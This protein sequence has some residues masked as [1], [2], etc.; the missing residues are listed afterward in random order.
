MKY[1]KSRIQRRSFI[2]TAGTIASG[3]ALAP[4]TIL[5]G[6]NK[7]PGHNYHQL[8]RTTMDTLIKYG[9]DHYGAEN[10]PMFA[11]ILDQ[12]TLECPKQPPMFPSV[13]VRVD[14][15]RMTRRA[16][17]S[18]N[19][20]YDQY[21]FRTMNEMTKATGDPKYRNAVLDA[22]RFN[23]NHAVDNRGFPALGGHISWNLYTE[24]PND[25]DGDYHEL[26][27]WPMEW[28]LWWA[29]DPEKTRAYVDKIWEC[30]VIDKT[31]GETNRHSDK[32]HGWSFS[33]CDGTLMSAWAYAALQT[34]EQKYRDW[35]QKVLNYHWQRHNP[36]TGLMIGSG[37]QR[38]Q[39]IK[40]YDTIG[41]TTTVMPFA[42]N[43]LKIGK[44]LG[45]TEMVARG[46]TILDGYAKYGFD[47]DKK[48]F[49]S[50]LTLD[51]ESIRPSALRN[52]VD[53]KG[54]PEGYL[55]TWLPDAGWHEMPLF[56]AQLYVWAAENV[57]RNAYLP[58][59]K[60]FGAILSRA[61]NERYAGFKDW[62]AYSEAVKPFD[63]ELY[64]NEYGINHFKHV[65]KGDVDKEL[66]ENYR[67]GG[68]AYQAPFGLFADHY[69]RM[70]QFCNAM[71]KVTKEQS[72][73]KLAYEVADEAVAYLWRDKLFVGHPDKTTYE[74]SDQVGILLN[75]LMQL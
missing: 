75:A 59:A 12:N 25:Q 46:R 31:T 70:I 14:A 58:T 44:Q 41:F 18:A 64:K 43:L 35:I 65:P 38:G 1:S 24:K 69:G 66:I 52:F 68:Y 39:N 10:S 34:G 67:M 8:V 28:D 71:Y 54:E 7:K 57:D 21:T 19:Q 4:G 40:R 72:W 2:K 27:F 11:A 26:W 13:S 6:K 5:Y 51:G 16:P 45:D 53:G 50:Q 23:L 9:R 63:R 55:A 61:W 3:L 47:P 49:Y 29:A 48:L 17:A 32:Q 33:W 74:N 15:G 22:L 56:T 60:R 30:H 20:F 73:N 36:K 62:F 42:Q 37:G